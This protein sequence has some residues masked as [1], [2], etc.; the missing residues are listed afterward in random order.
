MDN[1]FWIGFVGAAIALI[2]AFLQR[3]KV[4]KFSLLP[5]D[6]TSH[7][8][9]RGFIPAVADCRLQGTAGSPTS[10]ALPKTAL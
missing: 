7:T 3:N 9:I 5:P 8:L 2:F 10:A 4:M 6:D 1:M